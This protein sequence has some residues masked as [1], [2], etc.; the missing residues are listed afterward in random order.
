MDKVDLD[1]L[2]NKINNNTCLVTISS[3]NSE[4]GV[5]QDI[6]SISKIFKRISKMCF[7]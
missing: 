1:D 6:E 4:T 5:H 7:S 2:K 3:V